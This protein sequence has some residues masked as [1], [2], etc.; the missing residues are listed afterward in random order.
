M[1]KLTIIL[2]GI[3]CILVLLINYKKTNIKI[4]VSWLCICCPLSWIEFSSMNYADIIPAWKFNI[5]HIS[6][7]YFLGMTIEDFFFAPICGILFFYIY[8]IIDRG[9]NYTSSEFCKISVFSFHLMILIFFFCWGGYFGKYQ[10]L[11]MAIGLM[12]IAIC[13]NSFDVR[14]FLSVM[15][16]VFLIA[17]LWDI[18]ANSFSTPQ[19]WFYRNVNTLEYSCVYANWKF[20]WFKIGKGWFPLSILPYYY[21]SG[22]VFTYGVIS[23]LLNRFNKEKKNE[24]Q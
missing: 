4:L 20:W 12:C 16:G 1:Y 21:I 11:R 6:G 13:W 10:A 3:I 18:W 9:I 24:F 8:K 19:Q 22:G 2:V 7:Y 17:G 23:L 15:L 5:E 14:Q